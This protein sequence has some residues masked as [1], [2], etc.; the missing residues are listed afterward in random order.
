MTVK[1]HRLAVSAAAIAAALLVGAP[2][3]AAWGGLGHRTVAAVAM[4]LIPDK[5]AK[6]NAILAQLEKDNDFVDAASYP[7][8]YIRDHDPG[9]TYNPWHFADLPDDPAASF[10]CGGNC[11]FDELQANLQIVAQNHGDKADAVAIAWVLH[12]VGDL[13]QPLH[14]DERLRGG[15]GFQATY[16]DGTTC[17]KSNL[18]AIWDD[19]LVEEAA[20]G[21]SAT[22]FAATLLNGV[23]SYQGRPEIDHAGSQPWLAWGQE[24]HQLALTAAF[25]HLQQ[26]QAVGDD[27]IA[28]KDG[29]ENVVKQQ[30]LK[31][32][33]RLAYLLDKYFPDTA[34][35]QNQPPPKKPH[36]KRKHHHA[37]NG[38]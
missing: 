17:N 37:T 20:Q 18:H 11:L 12:L 5:A 24:S 7:D 1:F 38:G 6:M 25:D 29:A 21:Q 32:G 26:G 2:P 22:A 35:A 9:H 4:A 16:R 13:H 8:E 27:Y 15:N 23:K 30:L 19:C 36:R 28:G 31:G 33:I 14:M 10:N 3:A 34:A